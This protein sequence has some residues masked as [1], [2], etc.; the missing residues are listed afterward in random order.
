MPER[1]SGGDAKFQGFCDGW[2]K[3]EGQLA[4]VG[5]RPIAAT[6]DDE[7]ADAGRIREAEVKGRDATHR[8]ADDVCP[9]DR[10]GIE[11]G[12]NIVARP[13]LRIPLQIVGNVRRR[14]GERLRRPRLAARPSSNAGRLVRFGNVSRQGHS[15]GPA[16][17]GEA[18]FQ[19][20]RADL[21]MERDY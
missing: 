6:G 4:L 13:V 18:L 10:E 2:N 12:A 15:V 14:K 11:D 1:V 16:F 9:V 8:Q 7:R 3:W 21:L 17:V 19:R 5:L 20:P